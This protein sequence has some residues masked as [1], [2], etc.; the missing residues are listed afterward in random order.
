M[1]LAAAHETALL[2]QLQGALP[3]SQDP[4]DIP[5]ASSRRLFQPQRSLLLTL[6]FLN[7]VG[8]HRMWDLRGYT[9]RELGLLTGRLQPYSYRHTARF[10]SALAAVHA[11]EA[12]T[13]A[14]AC[15]TATLWQAGERNSEAPSPHFYLDGHRKTVYSQ[16]LIPRGLIG[17]SGKILGCRALVLLNDEQGHP[18]LSTTHRGDL[19][20][21][22]GIPSV[23]SCYEQANEALHLTNL[24][25]DR[26]AMAA[27]L[28]AQLSAE[29]RTMITILKTNQYT[30]LS[31][32]SNVG[33]FVPLTVDRHGTVLREVA[34]AQFLLPRPDR[35][36]ES[37]LL[38]V[39]LI[40]D[41][42]RSV[43]CLPSEEELPRAWWA[44]IRHEEVAWWQA[45]WQATP[46]PAMPTEPKLIPIVTTAEQIDA[47]TLARTYIHRWP[48]QENVIKDF[49]LPLGLDVNH[50][51]AKTL[52]EN[53]EVA[54]KKEALEKRRAN[55]QRFGEAAREKAHRASQLAT[56]LWKQAKEHGE[57]M[58]RVLNDRLQV[59]EAQGA[60]EGT[61]ALRSARSS[62]LKRTPSWSR[63]GSAC[64]GSRRKAIWRVASMNAIVA[65]NVNSCA[66]WKTW[67]P[68]SA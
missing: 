27:D 24:V 28:L 41:L 29:G 6:L 50:G 23:L 26:E 17:R 31:S 43:P 7:V 55:V 13:V 5:Q 4:P 30:G 48:A 68:R 25:V 32:F 22:A 63:C 21:T 57:E 33:S 52:V 16:T 3:T 39:A 53:S 65:N 2:T 40:R 64:I 61:R 36:D 20:L 8:L 44:D 1:L 10:L 11:D 9:G 46:A 18:R 12:W 66:H 67:Q 58:Y 51:F 49:L 14:L 56:K 62:K 59:L 19:H 38:S 42:R 45:G 15:W 60:T 35:Q 34:P 47:V 54:K 37:L